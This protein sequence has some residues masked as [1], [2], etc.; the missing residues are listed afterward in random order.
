MQERLSSQCI[1]LEGLKDEQLIH[2]KKNLAFK[3][4]IYLQSDLIVIIC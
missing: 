3:Y 2:D 4:F 1:L